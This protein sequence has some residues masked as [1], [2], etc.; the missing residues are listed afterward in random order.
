MHSSNDSRSTPNPLN[1]SPTV[2]IN[3]SLYIASLGNSKAHDCALGTGINKSLDRNIIDFAVNIEH[4]CVREKFWI[5][6]LSVGSVFRDI[7]SVDVLFSFLI[8]LY[9]KWVFL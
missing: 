6:L 5:K 2:F 7:S 4:I 9:V 3:Q 8:G 1:K